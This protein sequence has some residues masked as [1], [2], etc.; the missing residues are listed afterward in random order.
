M[1]R[2]HPSAVG[3]LLLL[4]FADGHFYSGTHAASD[5]IIFVPEEGLVA[6][7][8]MWPG[9]MLPYLS[10]KAPWDLGAILEN[11]GRIVDS[12]REIKHANMAR[13]DM[14]LSVEAFK[15]QYRYL[16][17]LWDGL[18]QLRRQGAT[19]EEAKQKFTIERDFPFICPENRGD[20]RMLSR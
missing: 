6:V 19:L 10:K 14:R 9:Q 18:G 15:E 8:D 16:K 4:L 20:R 17:T 7:G 11:W 13:S 3:V 2:R 1:N 5:I 12:G